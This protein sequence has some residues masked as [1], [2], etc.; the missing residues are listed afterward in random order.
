MFKILIVFLIFSNIYSK[1]VNL[2]INVESVNATKSILLDIT[3]PDEVVTID[4]ANNPKVLNVNYESNK[5]NLFELKFF[6]DENFSQFQSIYFEIDTTENSFSILKDPNNGSLSFNDV[7]SSIYF[8]DLNKFYKD[9]FNVFIENGNNPQIM[10]DKMFE[11]FAIFIITNPDKHFG[12]F[13]L[14]NEYETL[15]MKLEKIKDVLVKYN[16]IAKDLPHYD[17]LFKKVD[18]FE[19]ST[20]AEISDYYVYNLEQ[21]K[22]KI[23][24]RL[25][26]KKEVIFWATWCKPCVEKIN[27]IKNNNPN[28]KNYILIS[29][30]HDKNQVAKWNK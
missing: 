22:I 12:Y 5:S 28:Y 15:K 18:S 14:N 26:D 21:S 20:L 2:N 11:V 10:L 19:K 25:I 13:F 30:D 1:E 4:I 3:N 24:E 6:Y 17:Q 23:N 9:L 8:N 16:S 27:K 7:N 29:I